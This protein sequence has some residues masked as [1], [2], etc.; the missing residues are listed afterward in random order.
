MVRAREGAIKMD[1]LGWMMIMRT[2]I[3]MLGTV[4][5]ECTQCEIAYANG[6]KRELGANSRWE[7][8]QSNQAITKRRR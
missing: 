6:S 8:R 7:M 1:V 3:E 5:H 4:R 2:P